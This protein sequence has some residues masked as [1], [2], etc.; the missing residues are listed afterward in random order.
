MKLFEGFNY[1][2]C[3]ENN[4]YKKYQLKNLN[5]FT[6]TKTII[7]TY[8]LELQN[9]SYMEVRMVDH[10]RCFRDSRNM[11]KGSCFF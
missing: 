11:M 3:N 10:T 1:F 7:I 9:K 6:T 8:K 2:I 5:I 4:V